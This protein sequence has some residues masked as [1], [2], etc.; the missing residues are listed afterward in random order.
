MVWTH[1]KINRA[2][3]DDRTG[4]GARREKEGKE[5]KIWEDNMPEWTGLGSVEAL[6]KAEVREEWRKVVAR[7]S[8]KS[9]RSPTL[10]K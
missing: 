2:Y 10:R 3:K 1:K 5:K 4:H 7:Q 8:L 6:Q 9:Q